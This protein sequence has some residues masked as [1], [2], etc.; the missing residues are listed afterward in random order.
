MPR[1]GLD[2]LGQKSWHVLRRHNIERV[3]KDQREE[4]EAN[5]KEKEKEENALFEGNLQKLRNKNSTGELELP[6]ESINLFKVEDLCEIKNTDKAIEDQ[7]DKDIQ[8]RKDGFLTY[9]GET[10][11]EN[12]TPWYATNRSI[13][14][15]DGEKLTKDLLRKE[16]DDPYASA[17][18]KSM[19]WAQPTK[20]IEHKE[21]LL[22]ITHKVHKSKKHKKEKKSKKDKKRRRKS[23]EESEGEKVTETLIYSSG[24]PSMADLKARKQKREEREKIKTEE[25][26]DRVNGIVR[27][28]PKII[29]EESDE[30]KRTYNHAFNPSLNRH[31]REHKKKH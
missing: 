19:D 1:K 25:L 15:V 30:R 16:K 8:D 14:A 3:R 27:E 13:D 5:E 2:I 11:L 10:V 18:K 6:K 7:Q 17:F 20:K 31:S 12:A 28:K 21:K 29:E 22:Q 23:S 4:K 9:V 24:P 26:M